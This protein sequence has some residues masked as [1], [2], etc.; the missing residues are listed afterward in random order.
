MFSI[1]FT[2]LSVLVLFPLS[3][4]FMY[5]FWFYSTDEFHSINPSAN[6]FV[7]GYFNVH[8]KDW[9]TYSG[10]TDRPDELCYN[11]FK[12][13]IISNDLTQMVNFPP[14]IPDCDSQG[15]ALLDLFLLTLWLSLH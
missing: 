2:S 4:V 7:F 14:R 1:G 6:V 12:S 10:A 5:V 11:L 8:Y 9:L 15:P 3:I 13:F